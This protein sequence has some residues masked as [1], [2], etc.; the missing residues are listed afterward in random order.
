MAGTLCPLQNSFTSPDC[1][2]PRFCDCCSPLQKVTSLPAY[3]WEIVLFPEVVYG[4][5][6]TEVGL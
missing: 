5:K 3:T 1:L 6:Q 2:S 4:P